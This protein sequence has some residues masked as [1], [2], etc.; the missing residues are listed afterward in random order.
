M[1]IRQNYGL[2]KEWKMFNQNVRILCE[3]SDDELVTTINSPNSKTKLQRI[4]LSSI[5][6]KLSTDTSQNKQKHSPKLKQDHL[7]LS[8][9]NI[10]PSVA[11]SGACSERSAMMIPDNMYQN[12]SL[13]TSISD[14]RDREHSQ[15][16]PSRNKNV[17]SPNKL[18]RSFSDVAGQQ[19][20]NITTPN[21]N[22]EEAIRAGSS[23]TYI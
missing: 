1:C 15:Y 14:I 4:K 22:G 10:A 23:E 17:L 5:L 16:G 13:H 8:E 18:H 21:Y 7:R 19:R 2:W 11:G 20:T 12:R 6:I 3:P 9:S